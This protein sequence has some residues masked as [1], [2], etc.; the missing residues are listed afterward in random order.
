[1][2]FTLCQHPVDHINQSP[3]IAKGT[4]AGWVPSEAKA[5]RYMRSSIGNKRVESGCNNE[6]PRLELFFKQREHP[7]YYSPSHYPGDPETSSG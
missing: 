1:M 4:S 7:Q 2:T 5:F 3:V 6:A